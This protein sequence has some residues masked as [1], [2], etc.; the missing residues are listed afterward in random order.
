[1]VCEETRLKVAIQ[2]K[3]VALAASA[4]AARKMAPVILLIRLITCVV[5]EGQFSRTFDCSD[6]PAGRLLIRRSSP[7]AQGKPATGRWLQ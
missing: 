7:I 4:V 6:G 5:F 3:R 2:T 1:M